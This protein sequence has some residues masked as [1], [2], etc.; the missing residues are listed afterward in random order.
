MGGHT[1]TL[2]E[3]LPVLF[4]ASFTEYVE[5]SGVERTSRVLF[6]I[7]AAAAATSGLDFRFLAALIMFSEFVAEG[8]GPSIKTGL[9][10]CTIVKTT[11]QP[12][13]AY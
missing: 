9:E 6:V 5:S 8:G 1:R 3:L 7:A 4:A 13:T 12:P 2:F 10:G 11:C